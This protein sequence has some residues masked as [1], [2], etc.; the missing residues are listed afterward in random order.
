MCFV[1]FETG[2]K[3]EVGPFDPYGLDLRPILFLIRFPTIL[4]FAS[5]KGIAVAKAIIETKDADVGSLSLS[6]R[7]DIRLFYWSQDPSK[8]LYKV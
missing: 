6:M 1:S 2:D 5:G 8:V 4:F 3:V 7:D